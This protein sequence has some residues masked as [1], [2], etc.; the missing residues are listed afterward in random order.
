MRRLVLTALLL[1][2]VSVESAHATPAVKYGIQDDNYILNGPGKL[3]KRLDTI[4]RLGVDVVRF[5]LEWNK[6]EPAKGRFRWG[7]TDQVLRGLQTRGIQPVVTLIGTPGW[8]NGGRA[9][10]FAPPSGKDFAAFAGD[11]RAPL[12]LRA[13]L[14]DLERA[15][16]PP[17]ARAD[18]AGHCTSAGSSTPRTRRSTPRTA[19]RASA[20]AS[21]GR[22]R[23]SA[24]VSPLDWLRG[25]RKAGARLDAYAH[26]PHPGSAVRDAHRGRLLRCA[27]QDGHAREPARARAGGPARLGRRGSGSG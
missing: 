4:D 16:P 23:T 9:P 13:L 5:T 25:M 11:G 2:A 19:A 22:A 17:L 24:G 10:R 15:E 8:A 1:A 20:A 3:G 6:I 14:A 21:P 7:R 27:L 26:H 12:P 18:G